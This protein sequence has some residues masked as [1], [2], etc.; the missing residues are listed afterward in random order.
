S[1]A[2][3]VAH[4]EGET[5]RRAL[6]R[7]TAATGDGVSFARAFHSRFRR[8]IWQRH[9]CLS[10]WAAWNDLREPEVSELNHLRSFALGNSPYFP[11]FQRAVAVSQRRFP[12]R[13]DPLEPAASRAG[14]PRRWRA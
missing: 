10:H 11:I 8:Q 5:P 6:T 4:G 2:F 13:I 14:F 7:D 12:A 9:Q 3:G 1:Q